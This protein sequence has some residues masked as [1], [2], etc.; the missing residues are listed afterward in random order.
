M[1]MIFGGR[2]MGATSVAAPGRA[3]ARG[4]AVSIHR[5]TRSV[6]SSRPRS[7]DQVGEPGAAQPDHLIVNH[8]GRLG[9]STRCMVRNRISSILALDERW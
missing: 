8:D 1:Q 3:V 9:E 4:A 2:G 7:P 5:S 6:A